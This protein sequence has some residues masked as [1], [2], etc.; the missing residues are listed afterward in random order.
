MPNKARGVLIQLLGS[1]TN[2]GFTIISGLFF[3]PLYFKYIG[4]STYGSWLASGN[5][6]SM[7]S[8]V[9]GGVTIVMAQKL[10]VFF[11]EGRKKE[12]AICAASG[13]F[14]VALLAL[15]VTIFAVVLC[16]WVPIWVKGNPIDYHGLK[17]A[18]VFA[19]LGSSFSILNAIVLSIT[20]AWHANEV[21]SVVGLLSSFFSLFVIYILISY[22]KLGVISL[23]FGFLL[24]GFLTFVGN[25]AFVI[26]C[27][28]KFCGMALVFQAQNV[29]DLIRQSTPLFGTSLL[30]VFLNNS[31]ELLVT[32]LV[33]PSSASIM[34]ITSK[35]FSFLGLLINPVCASF[36]AAVS[37]ISSKKEDF[38]FWVS[39]ITGGYYLLSSF[40][41][42]I[43]IA[44]NGWFV[45]FWVG[46]DKFGGLVLSVLFALSAWLTA[47]CNLSIMFLNAQSIFRLT[48]FLSLLDFSVRLTFLSVFY[49]SDFKFELA[50]LPL[51]E[52]TSIVVIIFILEF[53]LG[54]RHSN[55]YKWYVP[56]LKF[57]FRV[58]ATIVL[59]V[60]LFVLISLALH[61]I[62]VTDG[63]V[64]LFA[65][66][67]ICCVFFI[68][69]SVSIP[70]DRAAF[71]AVRLLIN[72][73]YS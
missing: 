34:A 58:V 40:L 49:F 33:G 9:E 4:I 28:P 25:T 37:S 68:L 48:S 42:G 21:P 20:R 55:V 60:S 64:S 59:S 8:I 7:I 6:L 51:I 65:G 43:A 3:V 23:G 54:R 14:L 35:L 52:C 31:R 47:K 11:A 70:E 39:K 17:W 56:T 53:N 5:I 66:T 13:I 50:Y 71:A 10:A 1:Y 38:L 57:L 62:G 12:F 63:F 15:V 46:P 18:F 30:G 29:K 41:F 24:R 45:D 36:Y 32:L 26:S 27:W 22:F 67:L 2:T 61:H 16:T 72:K 73:R 69:V 19:G 44:I